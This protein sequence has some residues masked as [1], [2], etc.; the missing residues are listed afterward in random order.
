MEDADAGGISS[1]AL[2]GDRKGGG[3]TGREKPAAIIAPVKEAGHKIDILPG[4]L[5]QLK[6]SLTRPVYHMISNLMLDKLQD[7]F[8][9]F[10]HEDQV[11]ILEKVAEACVVN[12]DLLRRTFRHYCKVYRSKNVSLVQSGGAAMSLQS[13]QLLLSDV[14]VLGPLVGCPHK[15]LHPDVSEAVF[16]QSNYV[17]NHRT[18][19]YGPGEGAAELEVH[20][21]AE[22]LLRT[23]V[24]LSKLWHKDVVFAFHS[25]LASIER[26]AKRDEVTCALALRLV[27]VDELILH[28]RIFS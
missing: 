17:L 12:Y 1:L 2:G 5:G 24:E 21:F 6:A 22:G 20:E 23:A 9:G 14:H 4:K 26:D 8:Q 18:G 7:T 27:S 3:S 16:I 10:S 15:L 13:W 25:A 11:R 28:T 19:R